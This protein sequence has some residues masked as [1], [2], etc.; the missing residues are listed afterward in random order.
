MSNSD[1]LQQTAYTA[2]INKIDRRRSSRT[3]REY[4]YN[5][6]QRKMNSG[7]HCDGRPTPAKLFAAIFLLPT[8]FFAGPDKQNTVEERPL[9]SP[10][11]R[12]V[13]DHQTVHPELDDSVLLCISAFFVRWVWMFFGGHFWIS[14]S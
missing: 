12:G 9:L 3:M 14:T 8:S 7:N 2:S 5:C 13:K 11:T 6:L 4:R 1:A 10:T